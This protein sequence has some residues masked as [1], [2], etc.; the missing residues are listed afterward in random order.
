MASNA[1]LR[2]L[3]GRGWIVLV[4]DSPSSD[5]IRARALG[6]AAADGA[7][8][9]I[10]TGDDDA[11]IEFLLQD[12]MDLGAPSGYVVDVM[13]EDDQSIREKL[14]DAGIVI[15][16]LADKAQKVYS[17]LFG[18]AI[19]GI[20]RA[21]ENGAVVLI[22]GQGAMVFSAWIADDLQTIS[23]GFGWLEDLLIVPGTTAV[24]EMAVT[25]QVLIDHGS[26]VAVGIGAGS[27]LALGPDGEVETW[28]NGEVSIALGPDFGA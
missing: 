13:S 21:F 27:A 8:A 16:G 7:V 10:S 23:N 11:A 22:E 5:V 19:E 2:W 12:M 1:V 26:A 3:D 9:Y 20:Q 6:I 25:R 18:A 17:A 4:G 28:G 14:S 15:I 24:S